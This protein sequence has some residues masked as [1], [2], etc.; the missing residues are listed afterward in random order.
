MIYTKIPVKRFYPALGL[1][2]LGLWA[3]MPA[4]L[5]SAPIWW[6]LAITLK[7]EGSYRV[8]EPGTSFSGTFR[9]AASWQGRMEQDENDYM[10]IRF[11][12]DLTKW[13]ILES[14]ADSETYQT[15]TQEDT[16]AE[17]VFS[18]KYLLKK[19]DSLYLDLIAE[20]VFVP[21]NPFGE[22]FPLALPAS[23]ENAQG[24]QASEYNDHLVEG[25]NCVAIPE[26]EIYLGPVEKDFSWSW[27]RQ[28]WTLRQDRAIF[29]SAGHQAT[30]TVSITPHENQAAADR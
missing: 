23:E 8:E 4:A 6:E 13:E 30:V 21:L 27:K 2:G 9:L 5:S 10:L 16:G 20:G 1:L 14:P 12:N 3:A 11:R 29:T 26:K 19:G 7:T 15:L 18:V 24:P 25:S 17:P 28:E 22:A